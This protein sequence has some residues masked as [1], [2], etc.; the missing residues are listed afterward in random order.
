MSDC[1]LNFK[2]PNNFFYNSKYM[3]YRKTFKDNIKSTYLHFVN[4]YQNMMINYQFSN[5]KQTIP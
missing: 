5:E 4:S 1:L 3:K 2:I